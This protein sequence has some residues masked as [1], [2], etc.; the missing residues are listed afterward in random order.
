MMVGVKAQTMKL[1]GTC[2]ILAAAFLVSGCATTSK[3][4]VVPLAFAAPQTS[5]SSGDAFVRALDGGL[6]SKID[7]TNLGAEDRKLALQ[8]EY[9]ALEDAPGGQAVPWSGA[10]G[11]SGTVVAATPYQVGTQNCRQYTQTVNVDGRSLVS[12][13]AACR[14]PNGT[15]TPLS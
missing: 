14:N 4:S 3:Q 2:A 6:I 9:K 13:G 11:V 8:A 7:G 12:R 15:W 10:T 1:T 5:Y